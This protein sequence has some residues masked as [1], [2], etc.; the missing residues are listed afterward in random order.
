MWNLY[1]EK[2]DDLKS[3][4]GYHVVG[5]HCLGIEWAKR[6]FRAWP[7]PR[8]LRIRFFMLSFCARLGEKQERVG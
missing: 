3:R 5:V 1:D 2:Y 8:T 4:P 7:S 6:G